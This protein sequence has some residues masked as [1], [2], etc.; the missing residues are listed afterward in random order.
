MAIDTANKEFLEL[1]IP[2][3]PLAEGIAIVPVIGE[4]ST[5]RINILM[6]EIMEAASRNYFTELIIDF[7]A[8]HVD[9]DS[10]ALLVKLIDYLIISGIE[11]VMAGVSPEAAIRL[12]ALKLILATKNSNKFTGMHFRRRLNETNNGPDSFQIGRLLFL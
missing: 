8:A 11:P 3:V 9:S 12:A 2:V 4:I 7:S 5:D 1:S 6:N 10:A